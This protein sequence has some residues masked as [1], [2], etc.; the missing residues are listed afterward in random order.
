MASSPKHHENRKRI[1]KKYAVLLRESSSVSMTKWDRKFFDSSLPYNREEMKKNLVSRIMNEL[2]DEV[3][4]GRSVA[5]NTRYE[6]GFSPN[7][8][9]LL[10]ATISLVEQVP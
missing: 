1:A 7:T 4:S 2:G 3:L 5:V 10:E 9:K 6:S 8:R